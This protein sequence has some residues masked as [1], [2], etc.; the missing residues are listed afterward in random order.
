[1]KKILLGLAIGMSLNAN[2]LAGNKL[3]KD[4][5]EYIKYNHGNKKEAIFYQNIG[6]ML[7]VSGVRDTLI[8]AS[9]IC[10]PTGVNGTQVF[11]IVKKYIEDN[12]KEWNHPASYLVERSLFD[13]FPCK[14][15]K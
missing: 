2:W 10:I 11:E 12:P 1:M 7:Y 15:K 6:F 3:V 8:D 14:K 5:Q 9:Y 13:A 4:M